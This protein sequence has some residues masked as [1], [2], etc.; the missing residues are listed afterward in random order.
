MSSFSGP[1]N[2]NDPTVAII[3]LIDQATGT[4]I[5]EVIDLDAD[6]ADLDNDGIEVID[7]MPDTDLDDVH[8]GA[9][10]DAAHVDDATADS[11]GGGLADTSGSGLGLSDDPNATLA[12]DT[13][14]GDGID[15]AQAATDAQAQADQYVAQGDYASAADARE[16]AENESWSAGD[17]TMLHGSNSTDLSSAH[18]HQETAA[19]DE[20]QEQQAAQSGDYEAAR[21]H[22]GDAAYETRDADFNAGGSDHSGQAQTEHDQ[23]DWAVWHQ[24]N[25]NY[26]A[27]SAQWEADQGNADAA[28]MYADHAAGE[29]AS[30]DY[31]GAGGAHDSTTDASAYDTS[32]STYEAPADTS[33]HVDDTPTE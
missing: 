18:D 16:Q 6:A 30:A 20:Q 4:E 8:D 3:E 15:H 11:A 29:Q 26:D 12:S 28:S 32:A 9:G 17:D 25:A 31:Y 13:S 33:Y 27:H 2:Q 22:A 24:D 19:Y 7:V 14:T 23:E 5:F 1:D 21:E 10:F